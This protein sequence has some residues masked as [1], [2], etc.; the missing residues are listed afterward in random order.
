M[1]YEL[2]ASITTSCP[3]YV[4]HMDYLHEAIALRGRYLR[5]KVSWEPHLERSRRSVLSAAGKCESREKVV[6]LG[7]G[8]LLDVPLEELS[9]L[10]REVVLVDIVF[11]PEVREKIQRLS[12][13]KLVQH[14]VT[15]V[16]HA[17]YDNIQQGGR[18]L[19]AAAPNVPGIDDTTG[20]VVSLN[21]LSQLWV[22][23]RAYALKKMRGLDEEQVNEWCL[24]ITGAHYA[25]LRSLSCAVCLIAD[26]EF[27]KRDREGRALIQGSTIANLALP[28]PDTTWIWNIIPKGDAR[29]YLSKELKVGAWY[30]L[31]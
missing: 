6:V 30:A 10:F 19:P 17:L 7:A 24:E 18:E 22:M 2:F 16:A 23:P 13:V 21:I 15:N 11:L 29:H 20:L 1:F 5:N 27:V 14:D 3:P 26:H 25:Y 9:S 8:L 31:R 4:R 28:E 12:N